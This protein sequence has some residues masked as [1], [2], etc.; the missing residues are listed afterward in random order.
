ME[1]RSSVLLHTH[2][3]SQQQV[4][5]AEQLLYPLL[6]QQ[7]LDPA[8]MNTLLQE[9][10]WLPISVVILQQ[11]IGRASCRERVC[12][13]MAAASVTRKRRDRKSRREG[14]RRQIG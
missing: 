9:H 6:M 4:M 3:I 7:R 1:V 10:L 5:H 12:N 8:S 14:D 11:Q 13:S 2:S